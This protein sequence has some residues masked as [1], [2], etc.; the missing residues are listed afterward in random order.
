MTLSE[1]KSKLMK[2]AE[3]S[4]ILEDYEDIFSDFDPR[5]YTERGLSDDFL[6]EARKAVRDKHFGDLELIFLMPKEKRNLSTERIIIKRLREHFVKH[7]EILRKERKELMRKGLIFTFSGIVLMLITSFI[8]IKRDNNSLVNFLIILFEPA[9]WFLFWEGLY[10]SLFEV[11]KRNGNIKFYN[12][13]CDAE[14]EFLN[15]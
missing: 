12:K 6:Q 1:E 3:I 9:S 14:I 5:P 7:Y 4:L 2:L 10:E 11:K 15:I 8:L 13:M